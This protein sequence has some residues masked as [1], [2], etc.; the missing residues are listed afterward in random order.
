MSVQTNSVSPLRYLSPTIIAAQNAFCRDRARLLKEHK[1]EFVVYHGD[2]PVFFSKVYRE[3]LRECVRREQA[4]QECVLY[5][6]EE[7][8]DLEPIDP[9][10]FA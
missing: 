2:Q 8:G 10:E 4:Q 9:A 6:I 5:G 1:G 7:E 3:A